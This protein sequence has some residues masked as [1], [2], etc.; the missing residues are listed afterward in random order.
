M[1][2]SA[3]TGNALAAA[4]SGPGRTRSLSAARPARAPERFSRDGEEDE[5]SERPLWILICVF[6]LF[7]CASP[8][9]AGASDKASSKKEPA[10]D[11]FLRGAAELLTDVDGRGGRV[12]LPAITTNPNS[13]PTYGILPV[14]LFNNDRKEIEHI[15]AVMLTNNETFGPDG[16]ISYYY[17][18]SGKT[19]LR[20]ILEKAA[21]SNHRASVRY[22][23]QEFLDERCVLR[24]D[25]NHEADGS[26]RFFGLGPSSS[27]DA[28]SSYRL[29]EK[30][31][32][33]A[34]GVKYLKKWQAA[35]GWKYRE[36]Q[37][38]QG[39]FDTSGSFPSSLRETEVFSNPRLV[40]LRDTRDYPST[41]GKGSYTEL[42]MEFSDPSFGGSSTYQF[43]GG[44]W[45]LYLPMKKAFVTAF[46][47]QMEW[48]RGDTPFTALSSLGGPRS[49]RGFGEGR[50]LDKGAVF[51][52]LEERWTFHRL[53]VVN[54][55]AE[56]Q[57]A[58]FVDFGTVFPRVGDIRAGDVQVVPGVAFRAV[59]EP[60]VVGRVEVGV[61]KEGP[62]IFVGIDYPF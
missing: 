44:E 35:L 55:L 4:A 58:P 1:F 10:I 18:P 3:L 20:V 12:Y 21:R 30:R 45:S 61:G 57:A 9:Y 37:V 46:H 5:A 16:S 7:F 60:T 25:L 38:R 47:F 23:S 34:M 33:V 59:V 53:E 14:W 62:A 49:L 11:R 36:T 50:F 22:E 27:Q 42:F 13:G 26:P 40:L 6:G 29:I 28:E 24:V 31:A 43:Y 19:T 54:S 51:F 15:V 8:L 48:S 56:F 32:D 2:L 17:Y 52:N 39:I 41:P